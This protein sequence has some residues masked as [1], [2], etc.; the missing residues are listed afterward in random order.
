MKEANIKTESRKGK[1]Q[2]QQ[3]QVYKMQSPLKQA[4]IPFAATKATN[5][6]IVL[7]EQLKV[8]IAERSLFLKDS[9]GLVPIPATG[10]NHGQVVAGVI[11]G[12]AKVAT[13][14]HG[15]VVEQGSALFLDLIHFEKELV[16]VLE[17]VNL[18][19][20]QPS[21]HV[22]LASMVGQCMPAAGSARYLDGPVDPVHGE[23][24]DTG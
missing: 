21:D 20:T 1:I 23:S 8:E 16:Q 6:N 17:G 12:V 19:E 2:Y 10:H 15:R 18:D 5:V 13:H 24:D 9:M 3:V 14:D 11:G 22:R 7:V 4:H